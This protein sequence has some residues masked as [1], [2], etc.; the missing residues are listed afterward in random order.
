MKDVAGSHSGISADGPDIIRCTGPHPVE[1]DAAGDTGVVG[2]QVLPSQCR[3]V[4]ASPTAQTSVLERAQT[5]QTVLPWVLVWV[6]RVRS[7]QGR[8]GSHLRGDWA[9][10]EAVSAVPRAT[11][12]GHDAR[13]ALNAVIGVVDRDVDAEGCRWR[14]PER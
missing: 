7:A 14:W 1:R 13:V 8:S 11:G 6:H 5:L 2:V 9:P 3:T 12:S 10:I 4:D